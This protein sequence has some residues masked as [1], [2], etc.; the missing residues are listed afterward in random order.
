VVTNNRNNTGI[1]WSRFYIGFALRDQQKYTRKTLQ[2]ARCLGPVSTYIPEVQLACSC[3]RSV[4]HNVTSDWSRSAKTLVGTS[5]INSLWLHLSSLNSTPH[6]AS[7]GE[8]QH[9]QQSSNQQ[10]H[11][12]TSTTSRP[13]ITINQR[14]VTSRAPLRTMQCRRVLIVGYNAPHL[15]LKLKC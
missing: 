4:S 11:Q 10:R 14:P 7:L 13:A 1:V 15:Y 9:S 2:S 8:Q 3:A 12:P 5:R 6:R